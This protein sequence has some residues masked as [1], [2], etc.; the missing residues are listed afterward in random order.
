MDEEQANIDE[1]VYEKR[2]QLPPAPDGGLVAWLQV[3][4]S[5]LTMASSWGFT[6]SFGIFQGYL[7]HSL[8]KSSSEISWIGS[9]QLL[10]LI[11]I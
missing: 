9:V 8:N 3:L 2:D 7:V 10:S 5:H 6:N 11:H 1:Y 4:A